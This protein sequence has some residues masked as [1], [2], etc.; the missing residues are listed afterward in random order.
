MSWL[1]F[2]LGGYFLNA[3]ATL[4]D[5]HLL[6]HRLP[7]AVIYTFYTGILSAGVLILA[8]FGLSLIPMWFLFL[9]FLAGSSFVTSFYFF[10][11][12]LRVWEASR[13][14]PLVGIFSTIVTLFFSQFF[15]GEQFSPHESIAFVFLIGAGLLLVLEE[16]RGVQIRWNVVGGAFAAAFFLSLMFFLSKMVFLHNPFISGFIWIRLG[17]ALASL[18]LLIPTSTRRKIFHSHAAVQNSSL[19]LVV[20]N[21]VIGGMGFVVL[22]YAVSLGST[23]LVNVLRASEYG[24]LF[25]LVI[26]SSTF[27]PGFV[28]EEIS[29]KAIFQKVFG[30]LLAGI[31]IGFL[32]M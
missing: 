10:Y 26:V 17:S 24:F 21:K 9:A 2:A 5:K 4:I 13:V 6:S 30:I 31:G 8:P 15:L 18:F 25:L 3:F 32:L 11:R 12:T 16:E 1:F 14:A 22:N 19:S 7:N 20:L 28:R 23:T 27:L 29:A